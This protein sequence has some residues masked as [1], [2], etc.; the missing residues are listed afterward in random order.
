LQA[1]QIRVLHSL[2]FV[3]DPTRILRAVRFKQR[4][5]F[6]IESRTSDLITAA[7][8][9]LGRITGERVRNE[10]NLLLKEDEPERGLLELQERSA[11]QAIHPA[12]VLDDTIITLFG[13]ARKNEF[14]WLV[15]ITSWTDLYW[16]L[17]A[18]QIS[19]QLLESLC[20]RLLFNRD[21]TDSLLQTAN[22]L[23]GIDLISQPDLRPSEVVKQLRES[24]ELAL[25]SVW[26]AVDNAHVRERIRSYWVKWQHVSAVTTGHTLREL[27]LKPGPCYSIVL[28]RL[29]DARLDDEIEDD[30]GE[31]V[32]LDM[33]INRERICDDGS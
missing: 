19:T 18:T 1:A 16:H 24:T 3:D 17:I 25:L 11:L 21:L 10:L 7:L 23:K 27:G 4:L 15:N 29:R 6:T 32:L 20:E 26:L 14:P 28:Q 5:G 9:M 30:A 33:L 31:T 22:L 2:S 13:A 8:P 12:F